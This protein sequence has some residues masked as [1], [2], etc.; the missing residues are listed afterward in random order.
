MISR[1][2]SGPLHWRRL[3]LALMLG[4]VSLMLGTAAVAQSPPDIGLPQAGRLPE[5]EPIT[6]IPSPPTADPLKVALGER[7]FGDT[8]LSSSGDFSCSSCHDMKTNGADAHATVVTGNAE[9]T[10]LNTLTV[11][12]AALSFRLGWQGRFRSLAAQAEASIESQAS[13]RSSVS[14]VVDT[15]NADPG[16]VRQFRAAY[17]HPPDGDSLLDALVTFERSLLTPGS[18]F[19]RWLAGD[20]SALSADELDGYRLFKSYGCSACHQG[21]NVGG[22]LFARQGV[23]RPL[24]ATGPKLVRVPSLRNVAVTAPY[25]HDGSAATLEQAVRRMARAQL[26]RTLTDEQ[27]AKIVAFLQT[28]TGS[29]RGVPLTGVAP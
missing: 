9:G 20:A 26:D 6:P 27:I 29:Y 17:G 12:N 18:R 23:F 25:F 24:V 1:L 14:D 19:D 4:P 7:L 16:I 10:P 22:N 15:L 8:R 11:F 5:Q 2:R 3:M 13:M 21:V 28:L